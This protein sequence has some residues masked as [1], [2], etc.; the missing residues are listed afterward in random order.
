V[1]LLLAMAQVIEREGLVNQEFIEQCDWV[2]GTPPA[3]ETVHSEWAAKICEIP[4]KDIE[5]AGLCYGQGRPARSITRS[6]LPSTSAVWTMSR[7]SAI[8]R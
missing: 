3:S 8:S 2:G 6:A 1:A 5:Q 7:A 4:A